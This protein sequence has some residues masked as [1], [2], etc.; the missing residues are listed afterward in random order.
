MKNR[1]LSNGLLMLLLAFLGLSACKQKRSEKEYMSE[2]RFFILEHLDDNIAYAP[3]AFQQIDNGFLSS[4]T[5]IMTSLFALQDTVKS[6]YNMALDYAVAFESPVLN[7]FLSMENNFAVD[8]TDELLL[9]AVKLDMAFSAKI[10]KEGKD[11]PEVYST[12]KQLFTDQFGTL[13]QKLSRYNLSAY[14]LDLSGKS[15]V[16]YLHEY[17]LNQ[18]QP[19]ITVFELST[20]DLAVL[21]FKDIS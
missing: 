1:F 20:K 12:L 19:I 18:G 6:Q 2:I 10:R 9:E 11:M 7:S 15:S 5:E 16:F 21:S 8:L 3:I 17:Q 13:N 14:H 4:D